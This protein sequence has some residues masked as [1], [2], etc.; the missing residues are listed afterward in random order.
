M[1]MAFRLLARFENP[2]PASFGSKG[3]PLTRRS[4]VAAA[5]LGSL[6]SISA[7]SPHEQPDELVLCNGWVVWRS[8]VPADLAGAAAPFDPRS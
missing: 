1:Q 2:G 3:G 6:A 7:V 4:V 8:E 5:V